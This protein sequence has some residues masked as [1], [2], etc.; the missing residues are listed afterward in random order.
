MTLDQLR[1]FVAVAERQHVTAAARAL[2]LT[3]SAVSAAV[4]ALESRHDVRLFHRVGRGIVL[5]DAGRLFLGEARQVLA[6]AEAAER[7]L[8]DLGSLRRGT[9]RVVASQTTAAYWLPPI[10]ARYHRLYPGIELDLA[11]GNTE[12][13]AA[14]VRDGEADLGIV[15]GVV[16]DPALAHWPVGADRLILVQSL[17]WDARPIDAHWL[18]AVRWVRREPGSGTRSTIDAVLEALGLDPDAL[19][20]LVMPSNES[21]RTAVEAGAGIAALS[22]LVVGPALAAGTLHALPFDLGPRPFHALRHKERYSPRAADA[23]VELLAGEGVLKDVTG[24]RRGPR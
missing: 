20:A 8:D 17:P 19:D 13:A 2:N 15:E 1:I 3:Q 23:L 9:L 21:V 11:L 10:L 22:S 24:E 16:D 5:T 14:K 4:A 12:Q 6:R 18:A 7:A